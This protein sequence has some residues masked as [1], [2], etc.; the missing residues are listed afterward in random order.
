VRIVRSV[1]TF[2]LLSL[3]A[4]GEGVDTEKLPNSAGAAEHPPQIYTVNYPLAWAAQQLV[5][6][7]AEVRF[8]APGDIDPAFWQPDLDTVAAYQQ[9]DLVLL[10]GANYARWLSRV[11][12][13]ENRLVDTSHAFTGQLIAA[14]AGPAHS[15][16]PEGAHS[17]DIVAFTVWLD[18]SLYVQQVQAIA[19]V[20][21]TK[22]PQ[23]TDSIAVRN[24]ELIDRL[25]DMDAQLMK[26]GSHLNGVPVLYSHPVYQ[27][28]QRRYKLN[29]L[30][31]H[32]EP[33]QPPSA[34]DWAALDALLK[35]HP[36]QVMLWEDEPLPATRARLKEHGVEAVVF[37]PMGNRPPDGDFLSGMS[38]NIDRL[39]TFFHP[40]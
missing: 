23:L 2:A 37:M 18:L 8:P 36:A 19:A 24:T 3:V 31:L 34:Q 22:F 35:Q 33:D 27:Y 16:G 12:L 39:K 11:S 32:W 20:L 6:E 17:H 4:C 38:A 10:N 5:E 29:G 26:L 9:A 25:T 7:G 28:F 21:A 1:L 30:A 15:H 13:P 40:R 14:D